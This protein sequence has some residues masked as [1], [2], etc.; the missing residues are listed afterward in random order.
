MAM[1]ALEGLEDT[2]CAVATPVGEGGIGIV[3]ISGRE[4]LAIAEQ[5]VRLRSG[6][7]LSSTSSHTLHHADFIFPAASICDSSTIDSPTNVTH[8]LLDEGLVVF[9]QAPRSFTAEDVV[10]LQC[11]GSGL[12]LARLCE[13]CLAAGA[14]LAQPGEFTKRAFLNGRLDLS[15]AEAVLDTIKARSDQGL[16]IAQRHLRG[17]L[18]REVDRLRLRLLTTLAHVEA[19]IDFVEEDISFVERKEL[20]GVLEDTCDS[21]DQM[22]STAECGRLLREGARVVIV[23]RPNVGKSSLLNRLLREDRAI[24]TPIPG[25]TRD[26]IEESVAWDGLIITLVDTAGIRHTDDVVETEGIRRTRLAQAEADLVIH[27][28]DGQLLAHGGPDGG[29]LDEAHA[30]I[31]VVNKIDL[32]DSMQAQCAL[33]SAR[34]LSSEEI[35]PVSTITGH[36]IDRLKFRIRSHLFRGGRESGP[37]ITIANVRHRTALQQARHAL[38]QAWEA[39]QQGLQPEL[40]AVDI[41]ASAEAL[42]Q[43]TGAITSDEVL[44]RIFSEF[45]IGK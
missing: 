5:V 15:Q 9:M 34:R 41:R 16:K 24:V 39:S 38:Q 1:P 6:Q 10:E 45:C 32:L 12:I 3:R 31:V 33:S 35:V 4:S 28:L 23:G 44:D 18:G 13:A 43:I 17:E 8:E 14:R 7:P 37:G 27:V 11:H 30:G 21:I 19:G 2:I 40:I 36:G 26:L 20:L 25:T 42:G 29:Q 22:L